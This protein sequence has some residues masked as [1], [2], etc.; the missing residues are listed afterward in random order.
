MVD[1]AADG[2]GA[3]GALDAGRTGTDGPADVTRSSRPQPEAA[4]ASRIRAAEARH[5]P[6][7]D[8]SSGMWRD[9]WGS[10][11]PY[12]RLRPGSALD[13][14]RQGHRTQQLEDTPPVQRAEVVDEPPVVFLELV[15]VVDGRLVEC[16]TASGRDETLVRSWAP[17][18]TS[19]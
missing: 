14:H 12:P 10:P 18:L 9:P 4:T 7:R 1:A 11:T 19:C 16:R 17:I 8:R 5:E 6:R 2:P 3:T 15:I 13:G